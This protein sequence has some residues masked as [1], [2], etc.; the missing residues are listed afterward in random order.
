MQ[1]WALVS[2]VGKIISMSLAIGLVVRLMTRNLY[3][4]LSSCQAWCDNLELSTD[5]KSEL[6]F[7]ACKL[8]KLNGQ[9]IWPSPSAVRVVYTDASKSGYGG[10]TVENGYHIAQGQWSPEEAMQNS[11]WRELRTVRRV[12]EALV[13]K[14][15][16]KRLRWFTNNQNV[17]RVIMCGSKK[18]IL[19]AEALAIFSIS[20]TNHIRIE[21]EW[22]PQAN[23]QLAESHH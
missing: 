18:L 6:Q 9:D 22:I 20:V 1:A 19:H 14:L 3:A 12:L 23:N 13:S 2:L 5:A 17:C 11:T 4:I 15:V 7:W 8:P 21:P 16:N 10:Y